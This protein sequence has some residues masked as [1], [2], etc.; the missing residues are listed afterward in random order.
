MK[1]LAS[2]RPLTRLVIDQPEQTILRRNS[3]KARLKS[4]EFAL[5]N[6]ASLVAK[7]AKDVDAVPRAVA[8]DL[9]TRDTCKEVRFLRIVL[10]G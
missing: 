7:F 5:L 6:C 10:S 3:A 1:H 2:L 8:L 9:E 4:I